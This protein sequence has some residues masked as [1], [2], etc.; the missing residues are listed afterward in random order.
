VLLGCFRMEATSPRTRAIVQ[1]I[2][3]GCILTVLSI[4]IFIWRWNKS[5]PSNTL[6]NGGSH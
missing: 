6:T 3:I 5:H 1:M 2:N 4:G